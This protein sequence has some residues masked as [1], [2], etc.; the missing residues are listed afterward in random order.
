MAEPDQAP[1][2]FGYAKAAVFL[3]APRL[4]ALGAKLLARFG[5]LPVQ[6][7]GISTVLEFFMQ[8]SMKATG[9]TARS[10]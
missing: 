3:I 5:W 10:S 8:R 6:H 1:V 9:S 2:G 7:V 4:A